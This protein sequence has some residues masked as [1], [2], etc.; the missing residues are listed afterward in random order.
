MSLPDWLDPL[1]NAD[2]MRAVDAWAIEEQGVPS[3]DL[4][5]RAGLG[6]AR[7]T[8]EVAADGPVRVVIGKGNNGGD[9]LVAARLLREEG[10]VVDVLAVA[11]VEELSGDPA[12]MLERLPGSPPE[13]FA[14]ERLEGSGAVVDALLGTGFSGSPREPVA[15]AIAAIN[16]QDAP[17]VACDVPSG[18]DASSGEVE[19]QAVRAVA[20]ATFHGS[21][22]GLHVMPG[23]GHAGLVEVVEI[24]IP[25]GAPAPERAGLIAERVLELFPHRGRARARS[26]RRASWSW[27]AARWA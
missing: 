25:R 7:V 18:V 12:A 1:Y 22:I 17:V 15:G 2:E 27:W 24:G 26:S 4:M 11:P 19:G 20:T 9:G 3:L 21:K 14:P 8:A 16:E 6:L 5:E 13:P 23:A 10:R